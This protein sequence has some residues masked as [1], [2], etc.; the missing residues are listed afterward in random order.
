MSILDVF[1]LTAKD[2]YLAPV[3]TGYGERCCDRA[4]LREPIQ[5]DGN[6]LFRC[7]SWS[8]CGTQ[9]H[10]NKI[11]QKVCDY[12]EQPTFTTPFLEAGDGSKYI[13][14]SNM[15]MGDVSKG[16][17]GTDIEITAIAKMTGLDVVTFV[18][19]TWMVTNA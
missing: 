14:D 9:D 12:I 6:C 16:I 11:R 1:G 10:H 13:K 7:I 17:W 8:L 4:S 3:Y 15:R 18:H 5:G 19:G 2:L